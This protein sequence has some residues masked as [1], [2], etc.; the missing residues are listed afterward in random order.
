MSV[1]SAALKPI[2]GRL[3][4]VGI[5]FVVVGGQAVNLWAEAYSPTLPDAVLAWR[6]YASKDLDCLGGRA[7]AIAAARALGVEPEL[8]D[9]FVRA[10]SPVAGQ[11]TC[12]VGRERVLV[13]FLHRL[14]GVDPDRVRNSP[15]VLSWD[16]IALK[17]QHPLFALR[18]KL[19]CLWGLD[20]ASPPRQDLK[21]IRILGA[22]LPGFLRDE[23]YAN[24]PSAVALSR[25]VLQ[26][27]CEEDALKAWQRH[28]VAF[29]QSV[30]AELLA[31]SGEATVRR[32]ADEELPRLL[33][34]LADRRTEFARFVAGIA[35]KPAPRPQIGGPKRGG[36]GRR[37][38]I[39]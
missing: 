10:T 2:Y 28:G 18:G 33:K 13:Q 39:L 14:Y 15:R 9:P 30:P 8:S 22:I 23:S 25:G 17:V 34:T 29:E 24:L 31:R 26:L 6:P 7:A 3:V 1:D 20:Q 27:A 38:L 32:F 5:D 35:T 19:A 11:F 21:H 4:E 36:L 12:P 16:G 37:G